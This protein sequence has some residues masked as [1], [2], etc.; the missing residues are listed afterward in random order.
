[1]APEKAWGFCPQC[2]GKVDLEVGDPLLRCTF[3]KT[4]LYIRPES[5]I[6]SYIL[7]PIDSAAP[8][9]GSLVFLPYWRFKGF[10]FRL[11][12][13]KSVKTSL[14]DSTISALSG[15]DGLPSLGLAT[16]LSDMR[17]DTGPLHL[18]KSFLAPQ[19]AIRKVDRQ[20]E[21]GLR[22]HPVSSFILSEKITIISAPFE[23][24]EKNEKLLLRPL[25][26]KRRGFFK[27]KRNGALE[28]YLKNSRQHPASQ[29]KGSASNV[30]VGFIPLICP[31]CGNDLP[32]LSMASVIFCKA[33]KRLWS[34]G[35]GRFLPK[36]AHILTRQ[37]E[38]GM[39]FLPFYHFSL[40]L[41]GF[42]FPDRR[43]FL[44]HLF[45]YK[46]FPE[47]LSKEPVQLVVPAFSV[48]PSLFI[49]LGKRIS[50]SQIPFITLKS[51]DAATVPDSHCINLGVDTA[52]QSLSFLFLSLMKNRKKMVEAAD[53]TKML[54]KEIRLLF[55]PFNKER[56]ELVEPFTGQAVPRAALRYGLNL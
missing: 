39:K 45:P 16:Q 42:P 8:L 25:W 41:Q 13:D 15:L 27:V 40:E 28:T 3:C 43:A 11:F 6:F 23:L 30:A 5:S 24:F 53:K 38:K 54:I 14:V 51:R 29:G 2:G 10:R 7:S 36:K 33:C 44:S 35:D 32:A 55:I 48:N 22:E 17:L 52:I 26:E 12:D 4:S 37:V 18:G 20:I 21:A 19:D 34:L 50:S 46:Q 49:R 1:M 47:N 31:E 9:Q 56:N